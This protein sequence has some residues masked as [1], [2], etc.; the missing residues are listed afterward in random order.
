MNQEVSSKNTS[1]T[2]NS[3]LN[4]ITGF[5]GQFLSIILNFITRT[6]FISVLG[7]EYLGI[8]GLFADILTMLSLTELG[9]DTAINFKLYKPLATGNRQRVRVLMKF[10][11]DAYRVVGLVIAVIG[12]GLIPALP[13]LIHDYDSLA[14]LHINAVLIFL[15][16]LLQSVSSYWFFASRAAIVKA[17]QHEYLLNLTRY[18]VLSLSSACQI[19][20]LVIRRNFVEYTLCLVAFTILQNFINALIA[21]R[22]YPWAFEMTPERIGRSELKSLFK[23]LGALFAFKVNGVVAFATDNVVISAFIG[24]AAVGIYSNYLLI[25]N[26]INSTLK[27]FYSAISASGGN[28]F[29]MADPKKK[30]QFFELINFMTFLIYGTACVGVAVTGNEMITIWLGKDFVI[31]QPFPTLIGL[32]LLFNGMIASLNQ[33]RSITGV[34]RQ[35]CWVQVLG[36]LINLVISVF[37][38]HP[39]GIYGVAWGTIISH[40]IT[41]F[42]IE[43]K[44]LNKYCLECYQPV[45]RYRLKCIKYGMILFVIACIDYLIYK[46]IFTGYGWFS[47]LFHVFVCAVSVPLG[48]C[49]ACW[50]Q[51]EIKYIL[52]YMQFFLQ[53][54]TNQKYNGRNND[55]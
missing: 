42:L 20:V 33:L 10:Y 18:I 11:R 7:K 21:K 43:A 9:L 4:I 29:A 3:L 27:R 41:F 51:D 49:L 39:F 16:Y 6:V 48:L 53:R 1:R 5:G 38:V 52:K 14:S 22:F 30:Y 36:A 28:L 40:F 46:Y 50:K 45:S 17:D 13:V 15:M 31:P 32:E 26:A 23:D 19:V 37:L 24:L 47:F 12:I 44:G 8:N 2:R 55:D 35:L 25:F 34:F 54:L